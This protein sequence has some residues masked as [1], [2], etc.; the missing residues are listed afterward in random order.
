MER[1]PQSTLGLEAYLKI[2]SIKNHQA[3]SIR[4]PGL[5]ATERVLLGDDA[6]LDEVSAERK[7]S[8]VRSLMIYMFIKDTYNKLI[9]LLD[10]PGS[11]LSHELGRGLSKSLWSCQRE[12][13]LCILLMQRYQCSSHTSFHAGLSVVLAV[14]SILIV[15]T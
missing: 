7:D 2:F 13:L 9:I 3:L 8:R 11:H 14:L 5:E 6:D 10:I 12:H 15:N 1:L 4:D